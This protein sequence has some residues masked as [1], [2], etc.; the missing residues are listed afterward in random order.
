MNVETYKRFLKN[1]QVNED[2]RAI[3]D[4]LNDA[5]QKSGALFVYTMDLSSEGGCK[6]LIVG[7]PDVRDFPI[8]G[9]CT[10]PIEQIKNA[11]AGDAFF[12]EIIEDSRY[13]DYQT[14]GVP[15]KDHY[16]HIIGYLGFDVSAEVISSITG[17]VL[18]SSLIHLSIIGFFIIAL[19]IF[20]F[21]MQRWYQKEL[22][23][24]VGDTENIYQ[25]E[26]QSLMASVQSLRHDFS[27]HIQVVHG[28]LKIGKEEVALGYLNDLAKDIHSIESVKLN[29]DNPG[30]SVLLETKRLSAQNYNIDISMDISNHP[31]D[32]MKTLDLI[33][34]L[35]NLIDNAIEAA[36]ELPE[37]QRKLAVICKANED[38]YLF[39]V[40]NTGP[41]ILDKDI[42]FKRGYSTKKKKAEDE[43]RGQGL[44]IVKEL[45]QQYGGTLDLD[46]NK[47]GTFIRVAIPV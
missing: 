24:E 20:L 30:L 41:E 31:F 8:G 19:V 6:S 32:Q 42:I 2:Y 4:Y 9:K 26:F 47:E 44:F 15:I 36:I 13:D 29:I 25:A 39:E 38:E 45:V 22:K 11:E 28:L 1:P 34:M 17:K 37:S 35:S 12:T 43:T 7:M 3:H 40:N 27:N 14:V 18:K 16:G 23:K 10:V 46:S 21:F 5:R 33:K